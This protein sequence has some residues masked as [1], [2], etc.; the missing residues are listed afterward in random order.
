MLYIANAKDSLHITN[1]LW[2]VNM[3]EYPVSLINIERRMLSNL[4]VFTIA[5]SIEN[6]NVCKSKIYLYL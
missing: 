2:I 3:S 6:I 5:P 4:K 1:Y